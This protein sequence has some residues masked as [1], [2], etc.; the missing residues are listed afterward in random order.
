MN[1]YAAFTLSESY[2]P[3]LQQF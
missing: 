3:M 2:G 1:G